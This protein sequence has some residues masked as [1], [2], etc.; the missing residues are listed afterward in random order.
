MDA[1]TN[2]LTYA[3]IRTVLGRTKVCAVFLFVNALQLHIV[4]KEPSFILGTALANNR[5]GSPQNTG[6]RRR[7][8]ALGA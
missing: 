4:G 5:A 3:K 2:S 7:L 1:L 8:F 6:N